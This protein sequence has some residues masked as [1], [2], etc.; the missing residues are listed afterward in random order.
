[1]P[2]LGLNEIADLFGT[3]TDDFGEDLRRILTQ[4]DWHYEPL[5]QNERDAVIAALLRRVEQRQ[6]SIVENEDKSRWDRGWGEN[7][8][9]LLDA[10][11]DPQTLV[12]K[13]IR[14]GDP[15]RL[16]GEFVRTRD[17]NFELHWFHAFSGWFFRKFLAPFEHIFEFGSGSGINIARLS[18]LFP[19][20]TLYG[21][22][23][24][25]PAVS[26]IEAL[27]TLR[28]MNC[29][30]HQFDFFHPDHGVDFPANSVV[31]TLG[32]IEQT[33]KNWQP[34]LDFLLR[35]RP[36]RVCHVEPFYEW[37]DP[38]SLVDYTA[39]RAHEVRNFMKGYVPHLRELERQGVI[40][41]LRSK[42]AF[43]GSLVTEG[44]SQLVWEPL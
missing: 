23:W 2:V 19:D 20:K 36:S 3:T 22:D 11:G 34:F 26:I 30:G 44:Y 28:G 37:Y 1:M 6:F 8:A 32:A 41:I 4:C 43:V 27:R 40:R 17:Q 38:G 13:Y 12:P 16:R 21:L 18:E 5:S 29:H 9:G 24:S 33:G 25:Q 39:I 31:L 42:R 15:I 35:K 7:L 14:A 10:N